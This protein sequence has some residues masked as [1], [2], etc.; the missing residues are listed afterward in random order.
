[1]LELF[2][3]V[4]LSQILLYKEKGAQTAKPREGNK[5]DEDITKYSLYL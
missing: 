1:M 5:E 4:T 3:I 2:T